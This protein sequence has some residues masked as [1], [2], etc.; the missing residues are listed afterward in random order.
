MKLRS[1]LI[2]FSCFCCASAN[3]RS[4]LL[5]SAAA[6]MD[7]VL[8]VRHSL[9]A[10]IWLNPSTI[11]SSAFSREQPDAASSAAETASSASCRMSFIGFPAPASERRG[12]VQSEAARL[13]QQLVDQRGPKR[14]QLD[15][16][17]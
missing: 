2:W 14:R 16:E 13:D 1:A 15:F 5:V 10:P 17:L 3:R 7:S 6:L 9:S 12:F 8:A 11:R 4:M